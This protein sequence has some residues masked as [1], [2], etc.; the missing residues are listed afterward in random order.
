VNVPSVTTFP[1][2]VSSELPFPFSHFPFRIHETRPAPAPKLL[3]IRGKY[4]TRVARRC[5]LPN[6]G[7]QVTTTVIGLAACWV[8]LVIRNRPSRLTSN[9]LIASTKGT[10]REDQ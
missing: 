7:C 8:K 5:H 3:D 4:L 9:V 6:A 2:H 10:P 1:H